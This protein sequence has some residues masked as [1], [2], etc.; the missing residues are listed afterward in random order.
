VTPHIASVTRPKTASQAVI[1]QIAR[2]LR[3][4]PFLHVVDRSRGY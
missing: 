2:H 3:G 1:A 4:E